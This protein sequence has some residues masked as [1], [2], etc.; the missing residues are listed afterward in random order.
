[1]ATFLWRADLVIARE[2]PTRPRR[3][4][5][6]GQDSFHRMMTRT[7]PGEPDGANGGD[8]ASSKICIL[9]LEIDDEL[10]HRDRERPMMIF[11]LGFGGT[12][13]AD[14]AVGIESPSSPA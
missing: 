8:F 2:L 1:M 11:S 6:I 13:E 3:G 7:T 10:A 12:K 14:H 4:W 9:S 5:A